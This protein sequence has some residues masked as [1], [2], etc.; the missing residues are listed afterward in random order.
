MVQTKVQ[1]HLNYLFLNTDP[2]ME[3]GSETWKRVGKSTE[4]TDTMNAKTTTYEY[5][6]D[7]GPTD[8]IE[9]YQPSTN[10]PLT[11]FVGDPVY[12]YI[13]GLYATQDVGKNAYTKALRVFQNKDGENKNIAQVTECTITVENYNFA[14][15]VLTFSMKQGGTPTHGTAAVAESVEDGVK[16]FTPVFTADTAEG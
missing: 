11:A 2:E 5:I 16:I 1:K 14:T 4:W 3:S 12:E 9:N 7:A 6:E 10:M 13:F 15:G 8:V